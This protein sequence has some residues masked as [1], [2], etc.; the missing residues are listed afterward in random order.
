MWAFDEVIDKMKINL[1]YFKITYIIMNGLKKVN[2]IV[3]LL[4]NLLK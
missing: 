4:M 1:F 2:Y 3:I